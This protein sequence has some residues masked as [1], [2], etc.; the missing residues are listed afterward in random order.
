[1]LL[2][3]CLCKMENQLPGELLV[4]TQKQLELLS[5]SIQAIEMSAPPCTRRAG[6]MILGKP[7]QGGCRVDVI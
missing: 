3:L 2:A 4:R 1:M 7:A 5:E 6:K